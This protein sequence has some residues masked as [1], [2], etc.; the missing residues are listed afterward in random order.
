MM[1]KTDTANQIN[2]AVR[3]GKLVTVT[4]GTTIGR[5][6][7]AIARDAT[8]IIMANDGICFNLSTKKNSEELIEN[9]ASIETLDGL[10]IGPDWWFGDD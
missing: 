3:Q 9:W 5:V 8:L 6:E 10:E 7:L 2:S 4:N 1:L